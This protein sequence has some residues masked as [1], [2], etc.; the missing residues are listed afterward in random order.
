M[1]EKILLVDD[2]PHVLNGFQRRLGDRFEI[3]TAPG[4]REGLEALNQVGPFAVVVADMRM[5]V[6]DGIRF[7]QEVK[8]QAP[9]TVRVMLTGNAD[10]QTA[11]D[12]VNSGSI[13]KFLTKPC[14]VEL[15]SETLR[16]GIKQ[17]QLV[18]AER[19]LLEQ[20]LN[21]SIKVLIEVL[22]L[23]NPA[24]FS[25]AARVAKLVGNMA[26][27]LE[28]PGAWQLK[29]AA[30]LSQLGCI[31]VPPNVLDKVNNQIPLTSSE[32][33]MY[34]AHPGVGANLLVN[35]PRLKLIARMIERQHLPAE[36]SISPAEVVTEDDEVMLG[37]Q[38][39]TAAL[40]FDLLMLQ[41][42][43]YEDALAEMRRKI[44]FYNPTLL[45]TIRRI[46][47]ARKRER[48]KATSVLTEDT[49]AVTAMDL[50]VGMIIERDVW[51]K[52][53]NLLVQKGHEV[54][55][56]L[57]VRLRNFAEGV[58]LEEPIIVRIE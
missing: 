16:D 53:G 38:M 26:E 29:L 9:D 54:T 55:M 43:D 56:P 50:K 30:M 21:G 57:L 32:R 44:D 45:M 33:A 52:A 35:I 51:S 46:F 6:M 23:S 22:S 36:F 5:P 48:P 27:Q 49:A 47:S 18:I 17:Y 10:M 19:E 25:R 31:T 40:D 37:A 1:S 11:I 15:F 34:E 20:T 2:E 4:G 42:D 8:K 12:A 7:L 14:P 3:V 39:L 58:G 24:A 28:L 41:I 13:F